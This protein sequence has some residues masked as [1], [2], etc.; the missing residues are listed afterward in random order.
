MDGLVQD[1]R[2][3]ARNLRRSPGF[4]LIAVATLAVGIGINAAVFTVTDAVLFKGFPLVEGNDRLLYISSGGCC[5]SY[6]D[7]DDIRAQAKSFQ[8]MGIVHGVGKILTDGRGFA[9]NVDATEVSAGNFRVVGRRPVLG[10]DFT[11]SDEVDGAA[12]V[13]ILSYGFWEDRYGGDPNIIGLRIRLNGAP[14]TIIGIMAR[15]FSFP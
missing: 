11:H 14:A 4:A 7:F 6:P 1:V 3:A 15:G 13:A 9:E 8:G 12:P 5:I 10:R 2:Y